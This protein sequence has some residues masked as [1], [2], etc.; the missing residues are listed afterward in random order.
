M[1]ARGG[2]RGGEGGKSSSGKRTGT[3]TV[4]LFLWVTHDEQASK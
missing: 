3:F 2:R 1:K 4:Q